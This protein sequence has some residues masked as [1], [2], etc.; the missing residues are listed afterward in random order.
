MRALWLVVGVMA[1]SGCGRTELVDWSATVTPFDAGTDAGS[2]SDGGTD[3]GVRDAGVRDAGLPDAG[4]KPCID[5]RFSLSPAEPVVMLVIDRSCSMDEFFPG[6]TVSKWDA[7]RAAL[8]QTLPVVDET[9]QLGAVYFP[10]NGAEECEVPAITALPPGFGNADAILTTANV[11]EPWGSTPTSAALRVATGVLQARRTANTARG[12]V[13]AT[14]GEPTCTS[15]QTTLNDVRGALDA[16]VPTWVIGIE[17]VTRPAL[18]LALDS[19][20][21]AGG[22]PRVDAGS[23]YFPATSP[24]AMVE[25][26]TSI[27]DQVSACSFLTDSVPDLD[28]GITVTFGNEAVPNDPSGFS[29]WSWTDR[30]NGEL[31]LRGAYCMRAISMPQ[32]LTVVVTCSR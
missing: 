4:P 17:S 8:N 7:L 11:T 14:D 23:A 6:G 9:V 20:A 13:L 5:G 15:L 10:I 1:V 26:F 28:G 27:R 30:N 2:R 18:T 12:M 31:V 25:A 22:R 21:H 32:P 19:M 24:A 29:G 3:A 16:G